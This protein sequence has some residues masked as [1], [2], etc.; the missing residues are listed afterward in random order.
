MSR[1][2]FTCESC[3]QLVPHPYDR[4]H[5]SVEYVREDRMKRKHVRTVAKFC[6][7]CMEEDAGVK[8]MNQS[9]FFPWEGV[10]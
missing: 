10:S 9:S 5:K 4:W 7:Q 8:D 3:K 6:T 1:G 2:G